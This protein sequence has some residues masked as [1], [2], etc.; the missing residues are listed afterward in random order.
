VDAAEKRITQ[1]ETADLMLDVS[2]DGLCLLYT[3]RKSL[4]SDWVLVD[5][6]LQGGVTWR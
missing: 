4:T 2:P 5:N 3:Q 6:F 1:L